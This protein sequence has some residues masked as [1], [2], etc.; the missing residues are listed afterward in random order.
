MEITSILRT[1]VSFVLAGYDHVQGN[2]ANKADGEI[3]E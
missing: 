1:R 2:S 3:V